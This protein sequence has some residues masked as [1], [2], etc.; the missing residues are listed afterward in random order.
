M[1]LDDQSKCISGYLEEQPRNSLSVSAKSFT[2]RMGG[3]DSYRHLPD[4]RR[5]HGDGLERV[6]RRKETNPAGDG[7][8]LSPCG[9]VLLLLTLTSV[10]LMAPHQRDSKW[11]QSSNFN[12]KDGNGENTLL[13]TISLY[14]S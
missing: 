2:G 12:L 13:N 9:N 8:F 7:G 4:T 3:L 10:E 11:I 1:I 14:L 5:S 6:K